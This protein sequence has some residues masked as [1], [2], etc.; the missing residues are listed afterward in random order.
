MQKAGGEA[1]GTIDRLVNYVL[2]HGRLPKRLKVGNKYMDVHR[3]A[4]EAVVE[5]RDGKR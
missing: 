4:E 2:E 3:L 1:L 5:V